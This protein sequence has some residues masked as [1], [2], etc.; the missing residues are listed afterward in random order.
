MQGIKNVGHDFQKSLKVILEEL[1]IF[2]ML[3]D[4]GFFAWV[5]DNTDLVMIVA[6]VDKLLVFTKNDDIYNL[7]KKNCHFYLLS[8]FNRLWNFAILII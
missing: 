5:Q 2:I 8:Q 4:R 1:G 6:T 3:I 7:S